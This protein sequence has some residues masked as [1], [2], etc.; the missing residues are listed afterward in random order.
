MK[1]L[2]IS[3]IY[4]MMMKKEVLLWQENQ[5][6][7]IVIPSLIRTTQKR[8]LSIAWDGPLI[9]ND[10]KGDISDGYL[11]NLNHDNTKRPCI[12]FNPLDRATPSYDPFSLIR[13]ESPDRLVQLLWPIVFAFF[14]NPTDDKDKFWRNSVQSVFMA[15]LIYCY[16]C[17]WKTTVQCVP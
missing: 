3:S 13:K 6:Q 9:V 10:I 7:A 17:H 2:S 12:V 4:G 14:P 5:I 15:V 1:K 11:K 8:F 16:T